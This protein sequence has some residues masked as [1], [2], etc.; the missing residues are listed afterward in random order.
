MRFQKYPFSV[1]SD[2]LSAFISMRFHLSTPETRR[3]QNDAFS[4][5][6]IIETVF[7]SL[8]FHDL[9]GGGWSDTGS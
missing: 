2:D 5:G 8:R 7:E 1:S 6:S 3:F 9:D 4:K